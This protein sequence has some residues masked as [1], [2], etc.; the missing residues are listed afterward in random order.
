MRTLDPSGK[1]PPF[2]WLYKHPNLFRETP[3]KYVKRCC[4]CNKAFWILDNGFRV[5]PKCDMSEGM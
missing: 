1:L 5:C 4:W 2:S 3:A